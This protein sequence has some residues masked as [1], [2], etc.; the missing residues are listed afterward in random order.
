MSGRRNALDGVLILLAC[1]AMTG[2]CWAAPG[3]TP[4][5]DALE[6]RGLRADHDQAMTLL[7]ETRS[8][9]VALSTRAGDA[10]IV[11]SGDLVTLE[12]GAG[13]AATADVR[14]GCAETAGSASCRLVAPPLDDAPQAAGGSLQAALGAGEREVD[15]RTLAR[16][17]RLRPWASTD[18]V[19]PGGGTFAIGTGT[20]RGTCTVSFD[21][22]GKVTGGSCTDDNGTPGD[23]GDDNSASADCARNEGQGSCVQTTGSGTCTLTP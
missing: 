20:S 2:V 5:R 17:I 22:A 6:R 7:V 18:V 23:P 15:A 1:A 12:D 14:I 3:R 16:A 4:E 11:R 13:N 8:G 21:G 9:L 10:A 19:C